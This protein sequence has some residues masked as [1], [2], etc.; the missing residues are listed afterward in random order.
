MCYLLLATFRHIIYY[1][2]FHVINRLFLQY[3]AYRLVYWHVHVLFALLHIG[4]HILTRTKT[5]FC[6]FYLISL[7]VQNIDVLGSILIY[8][9]VSLIQP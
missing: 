6:C 4:L 8:S 3:Q 1:C 9:G 7:F 2:Y 5:A